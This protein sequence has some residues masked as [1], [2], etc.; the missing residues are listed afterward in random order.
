MSFES[1]KFPSQILSQIL[2]VCSAAAVAIALTGCGNM[3]TTAP[4]TNSFSTPGVITG[5]I[6]GGN[7][8]ITGATVKLYAVGTSGYGSAGTLLATTT[9]ASDAYGSFSFSQVTSGA[10]GP[11]GNSYICPSSSSLIYL[12]ST[13]GNTQGTGSSTNAAAAFLVAIGTCGSSGNSSIWVNEVTSTA[14]T[15]A[16][17]QYINPGTTAGTESVGSPNTTQAQ[18]GLSNAF[19]TVPNLASLATG[20]A[21]AAFTPT[22]ASGAAGVTL[23]GTPESAKINTIANILAACVNSTTSSATNCTTLFTNAVPPSSATVTSQP[24]ATFSK[25]VDTVQAGY[26]M[27]INPAELTTADQTNTKLTNL[28]NLGA[29]SAPFQ[30]TVAFQPTDWT[31]GITYAASGTCTNATTGVSPNPGA[32]FFGSMESIAVDAS[33]NVWFNNGA[34]TAINALGELSPTGAPKVCAFGNIL[35]GRG[36]TIDTNSNVWTTSG[37]TGSTAAVFEYLSGGT[38]LNWTTATGANGIVADGSG[39]VFYAPSGAAAAFQEYKSAA[40][41]T[42]IATG[43][44]A[45]GTTVGSSLASSTSYLYVP[46]DTSGNIWATSTSGAVVYELYPGGTTPTGGYTTADAGT[47]PLTTAVVNNGYGGA[48]D[49]SGNIFGGSTCCAAAASNTF[50]KIV[51]GT[52]PGSPTGSIS[53]KFAGGLVAPR[54]TAVDGAGNVWAGM[55]YPAQTAAVSPS[56]VAIY[57]LAEVDNN[58]NPISYSGPNGATGPT[59]CSSTN[60]NCPSQGGFEKASLGTVRSLAIDP[61]GNV[62]AASNGTTQNIVEVV[63]AAVP[64]VTPLSAG[65]K[66]STLGTKP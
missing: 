39:N 46:M 29:A 59:T 17:A 42:A 7:Q 22:T 62:W 26:Y 31:V 44:T 5:K 60:T 20:T 34:T 10:T 23:T 1:G 54:S 51:P 35:A 41:A 49:A 24:S 2:G 18:L 14:S 32:T 4:D 61:S 64:V 21:V 66:N 33:G 48:I 43:A 38:T 25:A 36:L 63:G 27:A 3:V 11:T 9:S 8:P 47:T 65:I 13:G 58:L 56:T 30:P 40:S 37:T 53:A 6:H 57:A 12:I 19:A 50:F 16:L 55:G 28:Y 15:V 52:T 45:T